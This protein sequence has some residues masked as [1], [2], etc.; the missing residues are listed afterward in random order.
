[1]A[2]HVTG[3]FKAHAGIALGLL[4]MTSESGRRRHGDTH[5]TISAPN[6]PIIHVSARE[7]ANFLEAR[8]QSKDTKT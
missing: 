4:R 1:M 6:I 8:V 3:D 5:F 7:L 2:A